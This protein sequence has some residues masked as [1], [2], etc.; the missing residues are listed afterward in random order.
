MITI[1]NILSADQVATIMATLETGEFEDGRRTTQ[2][3][4]DELK[5]NLELKP[6][7][8]RAR[9]GKM[10]LQAVQGNA[11]VNAY[12]FPSKFSFPMFSR[13]EPGMY[14]DFH[15]DAAIMNL[16]HPSAVRTDLS[17][18]V[19]LS[20]PDSYDGGELTIESPSGTKQLRLPAG[21]AALYPTT[22]LHR[23][24]EVSHGARVVAVFWIQSYVRD[25]TQRQILLKLNRLCQDLSQNGAGSHEQN[26]AS[27]TVHD[28]LRMWAAA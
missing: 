3:G 19:F 26:L 4:S 1:D 14:Y 10:I 28:L 18:T 15:T 27:S 16:G 2:K 21:S 23:V 22:N 17:C 20:E 9:L 7:A 5:R 24:E 25:E 13:Y 8:T 11:E 6:D 12:A